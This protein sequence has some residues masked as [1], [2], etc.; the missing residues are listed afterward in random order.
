M[1]DPGVSISMVYPIMKTIVHKGYSTDDYIRYAGFDENLL[2]DPEA[3]ISGDT[4]KH[5][6]HAAAAF[7]QD[8]HFGLHQGQL[9][10]VADLGVLGYVM[11][12]AAS[13]ADALEAYRRYNV[14]LC[15]GIDLEWV[16][17]G[18]D[19][20]LR[21]YAQHPSYQLS[22]HCVEDMVSSLY[23]LIGKL[24]NRRIPVR[25][26]Q[27]SHAGPADESAYVSVFGRM[28]RFGCDGNWLAMSK[29]VL[30]YPI[31]YSDSR[32]LGVFEGIADEIRDKLTKGS[33]FA[34]QVSRWMMERMPSAFP[35]LQETAAAFLMSARS[36]QAKLQE[37]R[38][39][40]NELA[41][42]VRKETAIHYLRQQH[43][44]VGDIAYLLHYSEPSVFQSAFKKWTGMTPRQ[45]RLQA[46]QGGALPQAR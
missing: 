16:V 45:Y 34:D 39:S 43:Y 13:I 33:A 14:I 18:D 37:E 4:L 41:V 1:D 7:T 21:L 9:T 20:L 35:T 11:M 2:Q 8:D 32:M 40:Y 23:G 38:T 26:I 42:H 17:R 30:Q 10:E 29:E 19:L 44:S 6:T 22:R 12:H 24:S 36:L 27:F 25:D 31:L 15:S 46:D 28:P 3:R 5:L